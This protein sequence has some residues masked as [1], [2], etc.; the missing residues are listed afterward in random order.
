[1]PQLFSRGTKPKLIDS[2]QG[3]RQS[4]NLERSYA[5][6]HVISRAVVGII[7]TT[8]CRMHDS[9][10]GNRKHRVCRD[11]V[12]LT[13]PSYSKRMTLYGALFSMLRFPCEREIGDARECPAIKVQFVVALSITRGI[14]RKPHIANGSF[15]QDESYDRFA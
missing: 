12:A 9:Y 6:A 1:M 5:S 4:Q 13:A 7:G 15:A 2:W 3:Y 10:L 8:H 14:Q 11:N